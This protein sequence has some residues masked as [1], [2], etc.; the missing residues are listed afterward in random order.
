MRECSASTNCLSTASNGMA[1]STATMSARG[2]IT[3][4]TRRVLKASAWSTMS[5]AP[6]AG[7]GGGSAALGAARPG[8]GGGGGEAGRGG[9]GGGGG[10]GV[11]SRRVEG[12][13]RLG[14]PLGGGDG[15]APAPPPP[16]APGPPWPRPRRR[17]G[18]RSLQDA[19][20]HAPP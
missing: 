8:G 16:A 7:G 17:S 12:V 1:I 14:P 18:D 15:P 4:S 9:A 20:R 10:G 2:V 11:A 3:S 6:L 5:T 13:A 19:A